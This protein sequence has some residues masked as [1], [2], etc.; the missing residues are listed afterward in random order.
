M[1]MKECTARMVIVSQEMAVLSPTLQRRSTPTSPDVLE[2]STSFSEVTDTLSTGST[3]PRCVS[4]VSTVS[5]VSTSTEDDEE[6]VMRC[7]FCCFK[8]QSDHRE[9]Q[10]QW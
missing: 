2:T 8:K 3:I 6:T 5:T 1:N 10:Y 9:S 4:F 7:C